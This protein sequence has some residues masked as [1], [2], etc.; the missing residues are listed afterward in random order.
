[1]SLH[2]SVVACYRGNCSTCTS[3][4][5]HEANMRTS[6][7]RMTAIAH[8]TLPGNSTLFI[9]YELIG[10]VQYR[11]FERSTN[12]LRCGKLNGWRLAK[13]K[14]CFIGFLFSIMGCID[15]LFFTSAGLCHNENLHVDHC[16]LV[17]A[18]RRS[19]KCHCRWLWRIN[20]IKCGVVFSIVLTTH[21]VL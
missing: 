9:D 6:H 14:L 8:N 21:N 3:S 18:Q 12:H 10:K 19:E 16:Y 17:V 7:T 1:M 13:S 2:L 20:K 5:E 4:G 11:T 15:K